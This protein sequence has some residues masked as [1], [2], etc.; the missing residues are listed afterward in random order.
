MGTLGRYQ[1]NRRTGSLADSAQQRLVDRLTDMRHAKM[2]QQ[3]LHGTDL[4]AP[5]GVFAHVDKQSRL[6]ELVGGSG[7]RSSDGDAAI[8][9]GALPDMARQP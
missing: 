3:L 4:Q 6:R 2:R 7:D 5:R 9:S 8:E 1:N